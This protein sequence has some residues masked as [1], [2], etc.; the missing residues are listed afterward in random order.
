[1]QQEPPSDCALMCTATHPYFTPVVDFWLT[2]AQEHYYSCMFLSLK[3]HSMRV[4]VF[5]WIVAFVRHVC[6]AANL[7]VLGYTA[8]HTA[9]YTI[10]HHP[11]R[12]L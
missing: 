8:A 7:V 1:M 11:Q 2:V 5:A 4:R 9:H 12:L 6:S 10:M 3:M